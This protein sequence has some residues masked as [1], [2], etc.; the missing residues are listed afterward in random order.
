MRNHEHQLQSA[1]VRWFRYAH[2]D[3]ALCLFA[4]PNGGARDR[5]TGAKLKAEGVVAGVSDLILLA[6]SADGQHHSLAIEMKTDEKSSRQ[7][8]SQK[9]W[10]KAVENTGNRYV[11]CRNFLDFKNAIENHLKK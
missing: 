7:S 1:C 6:P 5:V 10:Q 3:L 2:P 4:V 11:I 9:Q 8:D